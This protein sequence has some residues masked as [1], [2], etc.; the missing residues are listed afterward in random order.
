ML[1]F[2]LGLFT[3]LLLARLPFG[4]AG[5]ALHLFRLAARNVG[6]PAPPA[7]KVQDPPPPRKAA[8]A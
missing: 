1:L 6:R 8:G 3:G 4:A 2:L 7:A 5:E